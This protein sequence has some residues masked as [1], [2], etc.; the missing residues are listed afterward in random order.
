MK[1]I[2]VFNEKEQIIDS[3]LAHIKRRIQHITPKD[4]NLLR[5]KCESKFT[6]KNINFYNSYTCEDRDITSKDFLNEIFDKDVIMNE[7]G[8]FFQIPQNRDKIPPTVECQIYL[9][10]DRDVKKGLMKYYLN[11]DKG[12][13]PLKAN[14]NNRAQNNCKETMNTYYGAMQV[15][16]G[17]FFNLDIAETITCRGRN[18]VAVS[19]LT[20]EGILGGFIPNSIEGL[21]YYINKSAN[22]PLAYDDIFNN[23]NNKNATISDIMTLFAEQDIKTEYIAIVNDVL[24]NKTQPELNSIYVKNNIVGWFNLEEVKEKM[25][26][27]CSYLQDTKTAFLNPYIDPRQVPSDDSGLPKDYYKVMVSLLDGI[28]DM[29]PLLHGFDWYQETISRYNEILNNPQDTIR[30]MD[31]KYVALIDTD[32]NMIA[33][34]LRYLYNQYLT[35]LT[36]VEIDFTYTNILAIISDKAISISMENYT[37]NLQVPVEYRDRV[38][39]KNEYYY[40]DFALTKRKKNYAG[41]MC[42]KEGVAF[43]KPK[44]DVKGLMFIKSVVNENTAEKIEDIVENMVLRAEKIDV[45]K[46]LYTLNKASDDLERML[47]S[48]EGSS[49]Y[50]PEKLKNPLLKTLPSQARTKSVE[51]YNCLGLGDKMI[52]PIKFYTIKI[53]ISQCSDEVL[54]TRFNIYKKI[55]ELHSNLRKYTDFDRPKFIKANTSKIDGSIVEVADNI[56]NMLL[57]LLEEIIGENIEYDNF[58]SSYMNSNRMSATPRS[59]DDIFDYLIHRFKSDY[60]AIEEFLDNLC[61]NLKVTMEEHN[62]RLIVPYKTKGKKYFKYEVYSDEDFTR[63]SIPDE[64][65]NNLHPFVLETINTVNDVTNIDNLAAPILTNI[66]VSIMRNDKGKNL[67]SNVLEVF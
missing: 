26:K 59:R 29:V 11:P 24:Q 21:L 66:R 36:D 47:R 63:L 67:V 46:I 44:L 1:S 56:Y 7:N 20:I 53:D 31:R 18:M 13:D 62:N 50:V 60:S 23:P 39:M 45:T 2:M 19:A 40:S 34:L 3:Y 5:I 25:I 16:T 6:E 43:S 57:E 28:R 8:T 22:Y 58:V 41:L 52:A 30:D 32:S 49:Y 10:K 15:L 4:L 42:L 27:L 35:H 37:E 48:E 51:L 61:K 38:A 54:V 65:I 64:M 17:P 9:G 33:M 55:Y 14:Y 12:N